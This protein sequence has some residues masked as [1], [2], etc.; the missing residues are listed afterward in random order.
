MLSQMTGLARYPHTLFFFFNEKSSSSSTWKHLYTHH[1]CAF[2]ES[3]LPSKELENVYFCKHSAEHFWG[4]IER[5][6]QYNADLKEFTIH[7]GQTNMWVCVV[8]TVKWNPCYGVFHYRHRWHN[9]SQRIWVVPEEGLWKQE[10]VHTWAWILA[11]TLIGG[12]TN[13]YEDWYLRQDH[14]FMPPFPRERRRSF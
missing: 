3:A 7:Q 1:S 10:I 14:F 2:L 12:D 4:K 13:L 11:K 5:W 8:F 6:C 9:K